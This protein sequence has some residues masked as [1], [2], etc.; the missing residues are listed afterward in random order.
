MVRKSFIKY[1][2]NIIF[3]KPKASVQAT[4]LTLTIMTRYR[5]NLVLKKKLLNRNQPTNRKGHLKVLINTFIIWIIAVII[6]CPD[7]LNYSTVEI[8]IE[9]NFSIKQC[10]LANKTGKW[11]KYTNVITVITAYALPLTIITLYYTR[12]LSLLASS[13]TKLV[14]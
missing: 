12:L 5:C 8:Q 7:L 2:C 6:S 4:C 14:R 10:R 1:L 3:S 11:I 13:Q 9:E